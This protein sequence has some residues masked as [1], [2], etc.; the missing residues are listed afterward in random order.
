MQQWHKNKEKEKKEESSSTT[1]W[2]FTVFCFCFVLKND[3]SLCKAEQGSL[4]FLWLKT[5]LI[6]NIKRRQWWYWKSHGDKSQECFP[7]WQYWSVSWEKVYQWHFIK[8]QGALK[9]K[10]I[11]IELAGIDSK[12][13]RRYCSATTLTKGVQFQQC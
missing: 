1:H 10:E 4:W 6:W 2:I 5:L 7:L 3:L 8:L 9:S 13:N 11:E 12:F